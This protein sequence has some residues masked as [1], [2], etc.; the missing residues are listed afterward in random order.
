VRREIKRARFL[1]LLPFTGDHLRITGTAVIA[2]ARPAAEGEAVEGEASQAEATAILPEEEAAIVA[3]E[4]SEA[5][6]ADVEP[7]EE[8]R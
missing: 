7:A 6:V 2:G 3:P 8:T 4:E 5:G 1:G